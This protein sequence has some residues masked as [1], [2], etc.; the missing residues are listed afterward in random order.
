MTQLATQ[1]SIITII[2]MLTAVGSSQWEKFQEL[3]QAFV[4]QYG[5]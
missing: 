5:V 4:S 2:P 1:V 3:E